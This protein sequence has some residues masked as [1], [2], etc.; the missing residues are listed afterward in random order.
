MSL[1]TL[2]YLIIC[3]FS[4]SNLYSITLDEAYD[5]AIKQS[6]KLSIQSESLVQAE[7]QYRQAIASILP[8]IK[9]CCILLKVC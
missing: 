1:R 6:D 4:L 9:G 8:T 7:A 5:A 2:F 3:F